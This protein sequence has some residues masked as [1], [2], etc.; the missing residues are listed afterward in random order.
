MSILRE[1]FAELFGMFVADARLT[2]A[3]LCVVAV[4]AALIRLAGMAPLLGGGVL[5]AGCL[6][7]LISAVLS[8]G[9]PK[10]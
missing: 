9:R 3:I 8:A 10:G 7:V 1:V 2:V 4:A 5:L 6:G